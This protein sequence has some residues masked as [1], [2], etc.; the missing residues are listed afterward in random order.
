MSKILEYASKNNLITT[1][2]P[3]SVW[4]SSVPKLIAWYKSLG[5]ITNKGKNKDFGHQYLMYKTPQL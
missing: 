1:V 4:G 2:T 3:D 5:F